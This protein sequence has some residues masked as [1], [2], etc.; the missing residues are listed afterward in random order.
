[1]LQRNEMKDYEDG[2]R[3]SASSKLQKKHVKC[4]EIQLKKICDSLSKF[5]P[6]NF[7]EYFVN[8]YERFG[9]KVHIYDHYEE[10]YMDHIMLKEE[11]HDIIIYMDRDTRDDD[12]TKNSTKIW[13]VDTGRKIRIYQVTDMISVRICEPEINGSYYGVPFSAEINAC[14][15]TYLYSRTLKFQD[16]VIYQSPRDLKKKIDVMVEAYNSD[17]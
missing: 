9:K 6:K 13:P 8:E 15:E 4:R 7:W 5:I 16:S 10:E 1:M 11:T 17:Y 14:G 12:D 2:W 3:I